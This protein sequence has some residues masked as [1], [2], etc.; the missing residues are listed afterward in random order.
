MIKKI[1]QYALGLP[2]IYHQFRF[3]QNNYPA[4]WLFNGRYNFQK[5][6]YPRPGELDD[7]ILQEETACAIELD[8]LDQVKR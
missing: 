1:P 2:P 5:H 8:S 4:R 3:D 6:Y 7:D